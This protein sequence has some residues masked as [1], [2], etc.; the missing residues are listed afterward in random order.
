MMGAVAPVPWVSEEAAQAIA[1]KAVDDQTAG[2]A[3]KAAVSKAQALSQNAY[4]IT[5]AS[6]AVKRALLLAA[7]REIP[8]FDRHKRGEA[9]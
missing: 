3:G 2:A 1:G 9:A 7:G 5:L 4:K 8:E 6:V